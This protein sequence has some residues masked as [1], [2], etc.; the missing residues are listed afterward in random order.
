M[1]PTGIIVQVPIPLP[2]VEVIVAKRPGAVEKVDRL[3]FSGRFV[4]AHLSCSG[5]R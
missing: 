5:S 3:R 4:V 1:E 2:A